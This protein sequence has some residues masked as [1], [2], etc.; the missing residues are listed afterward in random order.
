MDRPVYVKPPREANQPGLLW[1]LNKCLYR[2]KDASRKWYLRVV[3]KLKELDFQ[4]S[5]YDSGMFFLIKDGK[6]IGIVALHVDDFLHAGSEYFNNV[7]LKQLLG[8][9]KIGK[10]ES[11]EFMYTGFQLTQDNE[12]IRLD[13][14]KYVE[15]VVIPTIDIA[16]MK[17][18]D[19]EMN[20]EELSLLRQMTGVVNWTARA[21]RPDLSFEMIDLST[22]F[23]GG[24]VDD[25]IKAKNV[26]ARLKKEEVTVKI[27]NLGDFNDCEVV[28]YTDAAY[29]NL[30]NNTD[31][32]GGYIVFI[33]NMKTGKTAPLEWKS[34]KLKR[35][36][37]S[38]LG[39]ETQA[40]YNGIDAAV[41]LKRLLQEIYDG[42]V[43]IKVKAVT[44][45]KSSR[46]AVYSESEV[47]ERILRGDIAVLK[48]MIESGSLA[49]I[50]WVTGQ[51]MLADLLT[52]RG[53]N[54]QPLLEVLE[55][56]RVKQ[57]T[58]ELIR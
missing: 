58:L 6:L 23:K 13:Q 40:L 39:A 19:R 28:V 55:H 11:K 47:S 51:N 8:C 33:I 7:I 16:L 35:R 24:K 41:G 36:V 10:S 56:G 18:R 31:S 54:K 52:K 3:E 22:K 15:N 50:R 5:K 30:N 42:K 57:E 26:A 1:L 34:G 37:H 14:K 46:D 43:D 12:G 2:L 53:V 38:T 20:M 9:F 49:E 32:C 45:N 4:T 27:S 29:R 44:D 17:D 48:Q 21:T 25:L